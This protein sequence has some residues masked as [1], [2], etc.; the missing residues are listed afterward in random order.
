MLN[1]PWKISV[2]QI[3]C[4]P[5]RFI[6]VFTVIKVFVEG[7]ETN[8]VILKFNSMI[9][10]TNY[11]HYTIHTHAR[12]FEAKNT[13]SLTIHSMARGTLIILSKIPYNNPYSFFLKAER[14]GLQNY[15]QSKGPSTGRGPHTFCY[16]QTYHSL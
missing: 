9:T 5:Q 2:K 7:K 12:P 16:T 14:Y 1:Y 10:F 6:E 15:Q 3:L 4:L 8:S 11:Q 13:N